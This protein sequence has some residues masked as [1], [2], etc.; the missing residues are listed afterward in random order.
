MSLLGGSLIFLDWF[1]D[2]TGTRKEPGVHGRL[3]CLNCGYPASECCCDH[4]NI[5]AVMDSETPGEV[6]RRGE[7][8]NDWGRRYTEYF[9]KRS[10]RP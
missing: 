3:I 6:Q 4:R 8:W 7:E 5:Q 1:L 10:P 9:V 2:T